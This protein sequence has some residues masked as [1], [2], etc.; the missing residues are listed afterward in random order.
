MKHANPTR[1]HRPELC[2]LES[3]QSLGYVVQVM[4]HTG[5]Y[6]GLGD[7]GVG[8]RCATRGYTVPVSMV[9]SRIAALVPGIC[10]LQPGSLGR[11]SKY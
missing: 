6:E 11:L 3:D 5:G 10:I 7:G 9:C 4:V 2:V 1:T 8:G